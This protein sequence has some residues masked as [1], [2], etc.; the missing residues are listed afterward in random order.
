MKNKEYKRRIASEI[1]VILG[2]LA[3]LLFLFRLWPVLLIVG[4]GIAAAALWRLLLSRREVEAIPPAETPEKKGP[5]KPDA[6]TQGFFAVQREITR[7]IA[8]AHPEAR[9]VWGTPQ[10]KWRVMDGEE[11]FVLLNRAGGYRE[12]KVRLDDQGA[13]HLSYIQSPELPQKPEPAPE[14][15]EKLPVSYEYLA[16]EWVEAHAVKLNERC[17]ERIAEKQE[18][19]LLPAQELP[20]RE[21][22]PDICRELAR[23]GL[24]HCE[25]AET[26]ILIHLTQETCRKEFSV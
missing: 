21:S 14:N 3:L 2:V 23:N 11:V 22:W 16:F 7:Q 5:E 12:A 9:W 10:A 8:G 13:V 25:C 20:D 15:S 17:N 24:E 1:L 19:L 18:S 26:G 6:M 4:A